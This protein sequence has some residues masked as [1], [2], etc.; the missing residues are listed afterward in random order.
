MEQIQLGTH[1]RFLR[2]YDALAAARH[3]LGNRRPLSILSFGCSIGD[4]LAT[5]RVMFPD[6]TIAGCDVDSYALETASRSVGHM[7]DVFQSSAAAIAGRGPYDLIC[8]F[9]SLC[10]NPL[11]PPE[12]MR[13]TFP[14]S[15]FVEILEL[16]DAQLRPGGVLAIRNSSYPFTATSLAA[17]Y[18]RIRSSWLWQSG[19]ITTLTPDGAPAMV[20]RAGATDVVFEAK[21]V[22]GLD[23]WDFIDAVFRKRTDRHP[24]EILHQPDPPRPPDATPIAD[25][26][27]S[28]LDYMTGKRSGRLI[29]LRQ[30]FRAFRTASDPAGLF[31]ERDTWRSRMNGDG[32]IHIGCSSW[33][34]GY[35][36]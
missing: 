32:E 34:Q 4:E 31:M 15:R 7:A 35:T 8:A 10:R 30:H 25:W 6:A 20:R 27:R 14:F 1:T 28:N 33:W 5:L 24:P 16:F 2:E 12:V 23:D 29:E 17:G 9:S 36:A 3:V 22:N 26:Q 21:D 18:D 19:V 11:P 13:E